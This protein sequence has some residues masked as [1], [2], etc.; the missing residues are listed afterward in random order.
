MTDANVER[1]EFLTP[2]GRTYEIPPDEYTYDQATG[3]HTWHE[4]NNGDGFW[5]WALER[6]SNDSSIFADYGDGSYRI[7]VVYKGGGWDQTVIWFGVPGTSD[8]LEMPLQIPQPVSPAPQTGAAS[9]MFLSRAPDMGP[10]GGGF[11]RP[12]GRPT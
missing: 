7:T 12:A 2:A 5:E 11:K 1:L 8:L 4:Y 10:G 3:T 9:G 6:D